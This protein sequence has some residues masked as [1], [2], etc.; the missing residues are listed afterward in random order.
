MG[1]A[2]AEAK[3]FEVHFVGSGSSYIFFGR[4]RVF[5][6]GQNSVL[7]GP[8]PDCL[9]PNPD[10]LAPDP[11]CLKPDPDCLTPDPEP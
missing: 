7:K 6:S 2:R 11:D 3:V 4:I 1:R 9:K 8:D 10:C 5:R